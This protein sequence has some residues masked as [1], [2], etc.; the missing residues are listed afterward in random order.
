MAGKLN[1]T[2][3]LILAVILAA[4]LTGGLAVFAENGETPVPEPGAGGENEPSETDPLIID[5]PETD[6][7]LGPIEETEPP[8][9][10]DPVEEIKDP[11]VP[12]DA[13]PK[14]GDSS[15]LALLWAALG[16]S[17]AGISATVLSVKRGKKRGQAD[18]K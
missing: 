11:E 2:L 15:S 13:S 17:S 8:E 6:P 18:G 16:L 1:K 14:T 3:A 4:S 5:I 9:A 7:P 10:T 12:K